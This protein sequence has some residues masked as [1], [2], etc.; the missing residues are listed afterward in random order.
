MP[1]STWQNAVALLV[2]VFLT[3]V[4][5]FDENYDIDVKVV[6]PKKNL[7]TLISSYSTVTN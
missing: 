2:V 1:A 6:K 5:A 7:K 3:L 4:A